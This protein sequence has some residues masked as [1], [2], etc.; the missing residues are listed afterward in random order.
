V[1]VCVCVLNAT[2]WFGNPFA[3]VSYFNLLVLARV[4]HFP[5]PT[6]RER[7][8]HGRL[9][10]RRHSSLPCCNTASRSASIWSRRGAGRSL[11][12]SPLDTDERLSELLRLALSLRARGAGSVRPQPKIRLEEA[13]RHDIRRPRMVGRRHRRCGGAVPCGMGCT[14]L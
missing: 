12:A 1:C 10:L 9:W 2:L 14:A 4:H 7:Q 13:L 11:D 3:V 8:G 5:T 6:R